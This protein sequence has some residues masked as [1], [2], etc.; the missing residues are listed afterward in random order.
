MLFR[1]WTALTEIKVMITANYNDKNNDKDNK[2]RND[3]NR[4]KSIIIVIIMIIIII[5]MITGIKV[6]YTYKISNC[7]K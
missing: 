4:K 1:N 7:E 3:N 6:E 2:W 5:I